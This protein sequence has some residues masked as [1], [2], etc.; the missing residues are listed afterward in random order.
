MIRTMSMFRTLHHLPA[1][2][3]PEQSMSVSYLRKLRYLCSPCF[4]NGSS[5]LS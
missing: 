5:L 2:L 1:D 4:E 3:L